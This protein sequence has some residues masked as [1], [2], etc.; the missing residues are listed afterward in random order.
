MMVAVS[1]A[2]FTE[3]RSY[4]F[5]WKTDEKA[6]IEAKMRKLALDQFPAEKP[7]LTDSALK[8]LSV[9]SFDLDLS[10]D[11]V[12]VLTAEVAPPPPPPAPKGARAAARTKSTDVPVPA[13]PAVRFI[14][15]IA[16]FDLDGNPA[17][18]LAN[19]TDASRLDVAPRLDLIDAVDVDGDG[20]AELLFCQYGYKQK[21]YIIYSVGHGVLNKI[22]E[23]ASQPLR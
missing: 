18:L 5:P 22:F 12:V 19:I 9:R 16:R 3:T 7:A 21:S 1:D 6:P 15:L 8:N 13:K 4:E 20:V 17:K 23:G 14:T 11:A 10:N 2:Q